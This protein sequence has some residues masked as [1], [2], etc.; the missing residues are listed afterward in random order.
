MIS[1]A[2]LKNVE[3]KKRVSYLLASI[4]FLVH[5]VMMTL[6]YFSNYESPVATSYGLLF[7]IAWAIAAIELTIPLLLKNGVFTM[8][9]TTVLLLLPICCPAFSD[10]IGTGAKESSNFA[11]SHGLLAALSYATLAS[12]SIFSGIYLKQQKSLKEKS[13]TSGM[14]KMPSLEILEKGISI[15]VATSATIM[16]AAV[17]AGIF[18][19]NSLESTSTLLLKFTVGGAIL[20][21]QI[22]LCIAA[23]S[24]A[25]R[26][27][28][29]AKV[30]IIFFILAIIMLVP[31]EIRTAIQ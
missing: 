15:F 10:V 23:I 9:P 22:F 19:A 5:S 7:S 31:I 28:K 13:Q 14:I 17:T 11:V 20:S 3:T 30:T 16:L 25:L 2:F 1:P 29:F 12:A 26:G 27:A 4:G 24:G 18:A 6:Q 8:F 21:A